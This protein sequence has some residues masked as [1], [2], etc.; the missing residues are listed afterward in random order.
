M[1]I[2]KHFDP[3]LGIDIHILI[4]PAGPIPI[5]HPH[6]ALILD[7]IDYI[8]VFNL[9]ATVWVGGVPRADAGTA[10][11][12]IPH[13]PL[14]GSFVKPPMNENEIFMGSST[15]IA[16]GAPLSFTA[17]PALSC[18]DIGMIAPIR[19]K[20]PKKSYGMVLPTSVLLAIPVGM[21]VMVGGPPTVDMMALAMRGG[22]AALGASFKK[23]RKM[24]KK[25]ARMKKISA[26]IRQRALKAM[27]KLG[28]PPSLQNKVSRGICTVTGHPVDV[29]SGKMFT[30]YVDFSLPGPLPLVWER[31]WYSTSVYDGP[32]GHGWHHNYDVKLCEMD[33]AVAVRMADGRPIAFPTLKVNETSFDRQERITLLRDEQGYALDTSDGQRY[34]F[35]PFGGDEQNQL[36]MSLS[37]K[38]SGATIQFQYD[39]S[40]RLVQIIDSGNRVIRFTYTDENK[41][42]KIFLPAPESNLTRSHLDN[43]WYCAVEHHYRNGMLEAVDD[44]LQQ[45]LHYHYDQK[46][47]IKETF[48]DGLSF[49]FEYDKQDHTARCVRTWG[50]NGIYLRH[51]HY[52]LNNNITYVKDS[53]GYV[54]TYH[55]DGVLPH[56][57]IDPLGNISCVN[58]NEFFQVICETDPLGNKTRYEFDE[59]GNTRKVSRPDGSAK[60]LI[61]DEQHNLVQFIDPQGNT[62]YYTYSAGN[63][64]VSTRDPLGNQTRY[65]Y[66][67][68]VLTRVIDAANNS[69]HFYYDQNFNIRSI[70]EANGNELWCEND[71]LGNVLS[72]IDSRGNRRTFTRDKLGRVIRAQEPDG[73]VRLFTYDAAD[74]VIQA[75]DQQCAIHFRYAGM[76]RLISRSQNGTTVRFEYDSEEQLTGIL[77]EHGKVYQFQLDPNGEI[78][79]ESGF[80]GLIRQYVRDPCR[81][82][83]RINRP[84]SRY[85]LFNYD[86]MSR[87]IKIFHSD[88]SFESYEYGING[89]LL[90]ASNGNTTTEFERN[91]L[92]RIVK[93]SQGEHWVT[94]HY[95][96]LG[97]RV[98]IQSSM[99]LDQHINRNKRGDVFNV[100]TADQRFEALFQ[101]DAQGLELER[102]LPGGIRSRWVRDKLGRPLQHEILSGKDKR[103]AKSYVWGI[104]DRLLKIIDDLHRETIFSHDPFG[105][106]V[107]A[108]Y[109]DN[110]FEMR[111]PDAVG[112]L[113]KTL[114][115]KDRE[116]GPAGQLLAVHSNKGTTR[117]EYD[118]EG[119]LIRKIDNG[120]RVWHYVWNGSGMLQKVVRPDGKEVLFEYDALGRRIKKTFNYKTTHWV[121]DGNNPLHE[122]QE[123]VKFLASQILL[124]Q[125]PRI[126]EVAADLRDA[127][128]TSIQPNGPPIERGTKESPITWLFEPDSF[129]PMAKIVGDETYSIVTDYLGTPAKI[130]D[131][132]GEA[133]WSAD[134]S[135]WGELRNLSGEKDFCPF[136][137]PGQYDD[138]ETGLYYNRFR[139]YDPSAGQY[140]SQ[141]PIGLNGS[142]PSIYGYV[143]DV[144]IK[145][146]LL[147]LEWVA[148][149]SLNF[150]QGY[151]DDKVYEY[152]QLMR[153][154]QWDWDR[155]PLKV[156]T[157][158]GVDVSLDNR[159]LLAAQRAGIDK[160]P[161]VKIE[162]VNLDDKMPGGGT[163]AGN[164]NKK[165]NSRPPKRPDLPK[166][167]LPSTGTSTQPQI[168]SKT[169][170]NP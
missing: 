17:L 25:S 149:S 147:G 24:Q 57:M 21:P 55:H 77:N 156:A 8:P 117:Y 36:L 139:Y 43:E 85:S 12:P 64:L 50:D 97:L 66:E 92:G 37:V 11:M 146:D 63:R 22:M 128:L 13:F 126:D 6:I 133:V 88:G 48:R 35:F 109:G 4:T 60:Q 90:K 79:T 155:S 98:R 169:C 111:I 81:R 65:E 104:N 162:R 30:D 27:D 113:F 154:G 132:H 39:T 56:K 29:A 42:H 51:L 69:F 33:D 105:S 89:D 157:V 1:L 49:Y 14:G 140:V 53:R 95:D 170:G 70:S 148:P 19:M 78:I 93:E 137:W 141:D 32:L 82:V 119:N 54:S 18:H 158:D 168:V 74:N 26:A 41:V 9:G 129:T 52:D 40:A 15:V 103:S 138:S 106:L 161:E 116:Y 34:R 112:N 167:K 68:V 73:N 80:D 159:R 76:G 94:S 47:L 142:S 144:N 124:Q 130:F 58:Y 46:L 134:I 107:S 121:W 122:W 123:P 145:L 115:Q 136:R 72:T 164:L 135:V 67:G 99:G 91:P 87:P 160:V 108:R 100:S 28:V 23:L 101:R 75:K 59:H 38:A 152:E 62:W 127:Q 20:K 163:Y 84:G 31:V 16:D 45:S 150:S 10:G 151:V 71:A 96:V 44:A 110:S 114:P 143:N 2:A 165:L 5:P 153:D 61:F 120:N 118:V 125:S 83:A 86:A 7:P 166:I 3:V 131:K 102:E